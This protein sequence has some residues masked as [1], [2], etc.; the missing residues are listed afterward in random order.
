VVKVETP[1]RP[2]G[3]RR[4]NAA[5]YRLLHAG[6]SCVAL[7][8]LTSA[9][10]SAMAALVAAADI[11]IESSRP[12]A[13]ARF[14][15]DAAAAVASG[16]TWVSIT[17]YGRDSDRVGYG[18]DVAASAGLVAWDAAGKPVFCGDAIAD[19]L[20][21]LAAAAAAASA[22]CGGTLLDISMSA[23]AAAAADA[24]ASVRPSPAARRAGRGWVADTAS[25][26][27]TVRPP[28]PRQ[29]A[30]RAAG[31]GENTAEVLR[32]LGISR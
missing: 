15:L 24:A 31:P 9:G 13:L 26:V 8:P 17:A 1:W 18:D 14:G 22:P 12:R 7:D 19:P 5:F 2:D 28:R 10:R 6:H 25:G 23:V 32:E 11:V 27:V 29:P 30:G 3:A 20:T 21:G 16:T 4:G